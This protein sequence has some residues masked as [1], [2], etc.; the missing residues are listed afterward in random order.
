M[1]DGEGEDRERR[2]GREGGVD[3]VLD[4][5][6]QERG[7]CRGRQGGRRGLR[8]RTRPRMQKRRASGDDRR[9]RGCRRVGRRR[10]AGSQR[11]A[12]GAG[13]SVGES[14]RLGDDRRRRRDLEEADDLRAMLAPLKASNVG[15]Y[16]LLERALQ[17]DERL[18]RAVNGACAGPWR[19]GRARVRLR[20]A[21]RPYSERF[22]RREPARA[23]DEREDV[24][25][26]PGWGGREPRPSARCTVSE[27]GGLGSGGGA[28]RGCSSP[29]RRHLPEQQAR[30][31][32][33]H[34]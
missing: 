7:G 18:E 33:T 11:P 14:G 30:R 28:R 2:R 24:V 15:P 9:R 12:R 26:V 19:L 27:E 16:A 23:E 32:R 29:S 20:G 31:R 4:V 22:G 21:G 13:W 3:L 34:V 17:V 6:R 5:G 10:P 8:R 1:R 25:Q